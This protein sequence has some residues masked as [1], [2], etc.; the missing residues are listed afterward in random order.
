M[1]V[2]NKW[3]FYVFDPSVVH[4]NVLVFFEK[5]I[6][7]KGPIVQGYMIIICFTQLPLFHLMRMLGVV[8][9]RLSLALF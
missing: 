3:G 6:N 4:V 7:Y 9:R 5:K 8:G 1:I 2:S